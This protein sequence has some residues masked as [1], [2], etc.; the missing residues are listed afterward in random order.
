M[1]DNKF[2]RTAYPVRPPQSLLTAVARLRASHG[3]GSVQ[4]S[5]ILQRSISR[6][7]AFARPTLPDRLFI[8]SY[9]HPSSPRSCESCDQQQLVPRDPRQTLDPVIHYGRIASGNQVIKDG[10][11][12]DKLSRELG[13]I[14][15]EMEA[16]GLMHNFP[17]LVIRG[18]CDY[19]DSH[20]I[21][22]GSNMQH[23]ALQHMPKNFS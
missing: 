6:L 4:L 13:S 5:E 2:E 12:R 8:S 15:F 16:A 19:S 17:C 14:C 21:S 23:W 10:F 11:T 3:G 9:D 1:P 18:I 20:K 7:P 22:A